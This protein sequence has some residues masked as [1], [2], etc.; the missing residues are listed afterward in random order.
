MLT[1]CPDVLFSANSRLKKRLE[2]IAWQ[3]ISLGT[4]NFDQLVADRDRAHVLALASEEAQSVWSKVE[5]HALSLPLYPL[6]VSEGDK[7]ATDASRLLRLA[8]VLM[9]PV[10][11]LIQESVRSLLQHSAWLNRQLAAVDPETEL[12]TQNSQCE[13]DRC[14]IG[15]VG[16]VR[17]PS[18]SSVPNLTEQL[19]LLRLNAY[20]A[21]DHVP[22][23][24]LSTDELW[25]LLLVVAVPWSSEELKTRSAES[26]IL[27]DFVS[28]TIGS[29][30]LIVPSDEWV[31]GLLSPVASGGPN[32]HPT[33]DDPLRDQ[34][35]E[36][37][38]NPEELAALE[39]L[40]KK[41][42]SAEDFDRLVKL[43]GR[44]Q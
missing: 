42:L 37:V 12:L 15:V 39:V 11:E 14:S 19:E 18:N 38:E 35:G 31:G 10:E 6:V 41:R 33:T 28:D 23:A 16:A 34:L 21:I 2:T 40:F 32:W 20:A 7:I 27:R 13:W 4:L 25:T 5:E 44:T 43:L 30:K 3:E 36:S 22:A 24:R 9:H 8:P 17:V 26:S 1:T 29:R